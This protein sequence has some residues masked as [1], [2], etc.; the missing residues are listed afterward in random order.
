MIISVTYNL[1]YAFL[2]LFII[3][4]VFPTN[5]KLVVWTLLELYLVRNYIGRKKI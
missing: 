1:K 4:L 5:V 2:Y 3:Y